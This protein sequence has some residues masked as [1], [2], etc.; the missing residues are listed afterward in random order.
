M[1]AGCTWAS[2]V[3]MPMI[4]PFVFRENSVKNL[5]AKAHT[6]CIF[7]TMLMQRIATGKHIQQV[8]PGRMLS[9]VKQ[10]MRHRILVQVY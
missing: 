1:D 8:D 10:N 6:E 2:P 5:Y 9:Y 3:P 7:F 4:K